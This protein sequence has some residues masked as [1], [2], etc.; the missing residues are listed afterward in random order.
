M[1]EFLMPSLGADMEAGTVLEWRVAPGEAVRR[2]Q[3]VM[4]VDTDKAE[5][6]A[7]IWEDGAV[8]EILVPV[9]RKVPVGTPLLRLRA[10]GAERAAPEPQAPPPLAAAPPTPAAPPR[11]PAPAP[12]RAATPHARRLARELGV[13]LASVRGTG[14][15]GAVTGADVEAAAARARAAAPAEAAAE[16]VAEA[17]AE[18]V[19]EAAAEGAAPSAERLASL[20]AALGAS[21]ARSKRE[22]P[23]YYLAHDIDVSRAVAWLAAENQRRAVAERLLLGVLLL[24]GTALALRKAPEL[25]GHFVDGSFRPGAGIHVGVAIALRGGGLLAPALLDVDQKPL[26]QLN[27]ELRDLVARARRVRLRG[28]ETTGATITVTSLG[29]LGVDEVLGVIQPPQVALVGFGALRE[30]PWAE[31]GK[32]EARPV[33]RATLAADHRVS[34]GLRGARLLAAIAR[35]LDAPERL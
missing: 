12:A 1:P 4:L 30:R 6:E 18:G 31:G 17:A 34:D 7:E 5:I 21:M 24:K 33:V 16:G 14:A 11:A 8:E 32:L 2:G 19:A 29:D 25:N 22:I 28:A 20:R 26:D 10:A 3:I 9:G 23:H 15:Q 13:D 27:A 35:A